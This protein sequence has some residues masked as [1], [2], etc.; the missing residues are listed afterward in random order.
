MMSCLKLYLKNVIQ[1]RRQRRSFSD[2]SGVASLDCNA[3][4][5]EEKRRRTRLSPVVVVFKLFNFTSAPMLLHSNSS[6]QCY[7]WKTMLSQMDRAW[8]CAP[9]STSDHSNG[10]W[11]WRPQTM[12]ATNHDD[13]GH[14]YEGHKQIVTMMAMGCTCHCC[15]HYCLPCGRHCHGLWPSLFVAITAMAVI[16]IVCGHHCC[17][18]Y[19]GYMYFL[20]E[21]GK[22]CFFPR[23]SYRKLAVV[24]NKQ[25]LYTF[26]TVSFIATITLI[27]F[28]DKLL[29][30]IDKILIM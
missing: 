10:V 30:F 1:S 21:I 7:K 9:R 3:E 2:G 6:L 28:I 12:M 14:S 24:G 25:P 4:T 26:C 27:H 15:G 5:L 19:W 23:M 13:D 8:Q 16:V 11:Q 18:H 22:Y 20:T 17:G 29:S